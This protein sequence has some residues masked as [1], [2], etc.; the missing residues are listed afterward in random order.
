MQVQNRAGVRATDSAFPAAKK[1]NPET[2]IGSGSVFGQPVHQKHDPEQAQVFR[3]NVDPA[4]K[5]PALRE[6]DHA[7]AVQKKREGD[8]RFPVSEE[9]NS[10]DNSG[11]QNPQHASA[12]TREEQKHRNPKRGLFQKG[13]DREFEGGGAAV[14]GPEAVYPPGLSV[15]AQVLAA[16]QSV[17]EVYADLYKNQGDCEEEEGAGDFEANGE[18]EDG[19]SVANDQ[20]FR[21]WESR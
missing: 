2:E 8:V 11:T 7:S 9:A 18:W 21:K 5:G 1:E 10:A 15:P 13:V 4:E 6:V 20:G 19:Q 16:C 3:K 14:Q 12:Q 17:S